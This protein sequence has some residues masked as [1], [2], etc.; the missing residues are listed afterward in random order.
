LG[1]RPPDDYH[2]QSL[3]SAKDVG[4]K[5][6][7]GGANGTGELPNWGKSGKGGEEEGRGGTEGE[8]DGGEGE[9]GPS[10]AGPIYRPARSVSQ[11]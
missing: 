10:L 11:R 6:I 5:K 7:G 9:V 4:K 3:Q 8:M 1:P 2:R